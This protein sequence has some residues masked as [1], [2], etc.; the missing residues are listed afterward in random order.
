MPSQKQMLKK[1]INTNGILCLHQ[2]SKIR[3]N[4]PILHGE[5][6]KNEFEIG[7]FANQLH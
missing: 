6:Q 5:Q 7:T 2:N 4:V 3:F 1:T